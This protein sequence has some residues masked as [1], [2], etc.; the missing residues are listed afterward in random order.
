MEALTD[1]NAPLRFRPPPAKSGES[2]RRF[3]ADAAARS[4]GEF[5]SLHAAYGASLV[6]AK[7]YPSASSDLATT[8]ELAWQRCRPGCVA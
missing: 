6:G 1:D 4:Y 7:R 5:K 3:A 8:S 2:A